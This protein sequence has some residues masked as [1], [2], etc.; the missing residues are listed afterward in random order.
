MIIAIIKR[1]Q[2]Q[3]MKHN[4]IYLQFLALKLSKFTE[5][6]MRPH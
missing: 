1:K 4:N 5:L 6:L 2:Q 3:L